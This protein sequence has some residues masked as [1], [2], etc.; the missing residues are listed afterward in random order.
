[1]SSMTKYA[2]CNRVQAE[3]DRIDASLKEKEQ[4]ISEQLSKER[5]ESERQKRHR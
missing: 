2:L 3:Q 5:R 4:E 1:M